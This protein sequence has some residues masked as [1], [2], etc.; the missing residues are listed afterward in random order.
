MVSLASLL[1]RL[2]EILGALRARL[3]PV[4]CLSHINLLPLVGSCFNVSISAETERP[5]QMF[6]MLLAASTNQVQGG[7]P[8]RIVCRITSKTLQ[9]RRTRYSMSACVPSARSLLR[10]PRFF[11]H[12][13]LR[14]IGN[15]TIANRGFYLNGSLQIAILI[16]FRKGRRHD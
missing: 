9:G 5:R 1:V 12:T 3:L 14:E 2:V 7:L 6:Q 16:A 13:I 8:Y 15:T 10:N 11:L 4:A